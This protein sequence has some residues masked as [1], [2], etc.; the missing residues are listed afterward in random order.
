LGKVVGGGLPLS[1]LVGTDEIMSHLAP[2]G[3]V[4][5]AGTLS[6]NPICVEAGIAMLD[7]IQTEAPYEPLEELGKDFEETLL[8]E[9]Q[10]ERLPLSVN[11]VGSMVSVF[12]REE[13]PSNDREATEINEELFQQYFWSMIEAGIMLPP[14]PF[15]A[16]FLN[17]ALAQAPGDT[18]KQPLRKA[19]EL[20]RERG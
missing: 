14:S 6:G 2:L 19:F 18:W 3:S 16:Y 1:G 11:R 4:Y 20:I 7:L 17:V 5:Q 10:R 9:I 13:N 15:E 12:A 8:D